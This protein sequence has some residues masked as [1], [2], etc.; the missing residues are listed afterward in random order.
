MVGLFDQTTNWMQRVRTCGR[1]NQKGIASN[2]A[3]ADTPGYTPRQ[4]EFEQQLQQALAE[5]QPQPA[6]ETSTNPA[7]CPIAGEGGV[8]AVQPKVVREAGQSQTGDG[9]GVAVDQEMVDLAKNEIL[10]E[11]ATQVLSKKF[12]LLKYVVQEGKG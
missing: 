7:F 4:R 1:E 5:E 3:N 9:N 10:Y 8:A 11:A 6:T 12:G 2:I